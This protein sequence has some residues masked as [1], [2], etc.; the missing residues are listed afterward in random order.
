M[1]LRSTVRDEFPRGWWR[2]ISWWFA[3]LRG[4]ALSCL[5]ALATVLFAGEMRCVVRMRD[6][7]WQLRHV[8]GSTEGFVGAVM[9][10]IAGL[11]VVA[12]TA[13][14]KPATADGGAWFVVVALSMA[15]WCLAN[16]MV[17]CVVLA[18]LLRSRIRQRDVWQDIDFVEMHTPKYGRPPETVEEYQAQRLGAQ[19]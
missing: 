16:V 4:I 9:I 15:L 10:N 6:H 13:A 18:V 11:A 5:V 2:S 8:K 19:H 7:P 3:S 17:A 12:A 14:G 1:S